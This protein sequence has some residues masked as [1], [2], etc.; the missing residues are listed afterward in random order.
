MS[1]RRRGVNVVMTKKKGLGRRIR[2]TGKR[3]ERE[4]EREKWTTKMLMKV[5]MIN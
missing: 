3:R 5:I 2:E 4:R 1:E